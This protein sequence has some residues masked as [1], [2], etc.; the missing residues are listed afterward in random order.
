VGECG[1][2]GAW[3]GPP[4]VRSADPVISSGQLTVTESF[5]AE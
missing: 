4:T 3:V 2:R 5:A 1:G